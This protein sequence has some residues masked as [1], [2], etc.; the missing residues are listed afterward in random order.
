MGACSSAAK[1]GGVG[2]LTRATG[3]LPRN[4]YAITHSQTNTSWV[5]GTRL[6]KVYERILALEWLDP[7]HIVFAAVAMSLDRWLKLVAESAP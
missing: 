5:L 3:R 6:T 7:D 1:I 2:A 4:I